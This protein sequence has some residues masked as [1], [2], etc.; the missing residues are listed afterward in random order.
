MVTVQLAAGDSEPIPPRSPGCK[1]PA[2]RGRIGPPASGFTLVALL[3]VIAII[4][5][6]VALMLPAVQTARESA[7]RTSCLNNL[8]QIGTAIQ[9]YHD[10]QKMFPPGGVNTGP[11]CSTESYSSWP[12]AILPFLEQKTLYDRYSQ[13]ETNESLA[14]G[15][16]R[17]QFVAVYACPS[18]PRPKA[19][20]RPE[21]GPA[22][23]LRL[24][25]MPGSYRGVGG[26]SD[27]SGW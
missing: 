25:Y 16:V 12:I 11:C 20:E 6:L 27:G 17:Q 21:S 7:R 26:R 14:N 19:K 23:D 22:N 8:H 24:Q 13:G 9:L 15:F 18:E 2:I 5:V 10:V 4:G 1:D 3:V